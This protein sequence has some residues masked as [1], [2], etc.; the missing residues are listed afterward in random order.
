MR[1]LIVGDIHANLVAFEAVLAASRSSYD[2]VWCLGDLVGY[3]PRPRE[4]I[5]LLR[6]LP[7]LCVIG[8]HDYAA[9][10]QLRLD[11][12]NPVAQRS[13]VW[14]TATLTIDDIEWLELLPSRVIDETV[15]LVHGSPRQPAWEYIYEPGAARVNFELIDTSLCFIGHTHICSLFQEDEVEFGVMRQP[16]CGDRYRPRQGRAIINPGSVGQPRD[17]DPRAAYAIFDTESMVTEFHRV[18]YDI[19]ATQL[20]MGAIGLPEPLI[21]RLAIGY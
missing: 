4:C 18:E 12:F 7:H 16:R 2:Y 15:T 17:G 3:G 1:V 9:I 13:A 19:T 20:Q 8:N 21:K 6:S 14:T 5:A 11:D 10:G